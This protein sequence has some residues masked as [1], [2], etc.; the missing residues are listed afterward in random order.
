MQF[1]H[2]WDL[3]CNM[4]DLSGMRSALHREQSLSA[5][6]MR[7]LRRALR[8]RDGGWPPTGRRFPGSPRPRC[9]EDRR[10]VRRPDGLGG[11]AAVSRTQPPAGRGASRQGASRQGWLAVA[12]GIICII[13][14][15]EVA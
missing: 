9:R 8:A 2:V 6:G 11:N 1:W 7:T 5:R 13:P 3:T 4:H 14:E 12:A 10:S 15:G